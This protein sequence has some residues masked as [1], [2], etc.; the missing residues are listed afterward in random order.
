VDLLAVVVASLVLVPL[1]IFC[2]GNPAS[3]VLGLVLALFSPGYSLVAAIF[4]KRYDLDIIRRLALGFG[5]SIT[6]V[7]LLGVILNFTPWGI[8]LYPVLIALLVFILA[9]SAVAYYRRRR[10]PPEERFEP[11]FRISFSWLWG[12]DHL[13]DKVLLLILIV[14]IIGAI[15]TLVYVAKPPVIGQQF[16]EFYML[17]PEGKA[18]N[19]PDVIVLGEE[20]VVTLGIV[21]HELATTDYHVRIVISGQEV[22]EVESVIL[23]HGEGWEQ[24]VSLA[25]T[26]VGEAQKVE[27][28]LYRGSESKA[29]HTL[30]LWVDVI[31]SQ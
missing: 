1:A 10:L 18:E 4:P 13:W 23:A 26:E 3:L 11:G 12:W 8:S 7:V 20:A 9:A 19:Y 22:G 6:V 15:G 25:P 2:G 30:D 5:L 31:G 17:G 24:P 28:Q 29:Y 21:N 27:F 14:V 16:T